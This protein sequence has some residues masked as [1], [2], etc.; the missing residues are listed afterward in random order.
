MEEDEVR[1]GAGWAFERERGEDSAIRITSSHLNLNLI[2]EK[3]NNGGTRKFRSSLI[4]NCKSAW[5]QNNRALIDWV[6]SLDSAHCMLADSPADFKDGR[7][8]FPLRA[9]TVRNCGYAAALPPL[10]RR[11]QRASLRR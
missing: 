10:P 1:G 7:S 4:A 2:Q 9:Y 11:D 5:T 8:D 6:N 3:K